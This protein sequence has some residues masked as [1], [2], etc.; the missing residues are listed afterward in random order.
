MNGLCFRTQ[1]IDVLYFE[2]RCQSF[3]NFHLIVGYG[4][5]AGR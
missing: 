4:M 1:A 5:E 3:L 2:Q